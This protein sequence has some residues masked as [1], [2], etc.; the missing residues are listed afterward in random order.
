MPH[1]Y[2]DIQY[3]WTE[4]FFLGQQ[5]PYLRCPRGSQC[6]R[7]TRRHSSSQ[8]VFFYI[9]IRQQTY[10]NAGDKHGKKADAGRFRLVTVRN[11]SCGKVMF[12]HL[13]VIL[14]TERARIAGGTCM[15]GVCSRGCAWQGRM[16]GIGGGCGRGACIARGV[17]G[18]RD[19]HCSGRYAS[20]WNAFLF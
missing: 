10:P 3:L 11:S 13:S 19:G 7:C 14:F 15:A 9:Q 12:L 16:C 5:F 18:R 17:R 1:Q 20:Y 8:T 4:I 6:C 2:F